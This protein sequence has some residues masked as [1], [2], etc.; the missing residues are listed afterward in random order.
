M[1]QISYT[2][3]FHSIQEE[4]LTALKSHTDTSFRFTEDG[5]VERSDED[6]GL[7]N[8]ISAMLVNKF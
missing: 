3:L 7:D 1:F 4:F 2:F 5:S 6:K 8:V